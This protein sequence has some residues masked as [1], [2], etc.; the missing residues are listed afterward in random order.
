MSERYFTPAEVERL[1]P[2]LTRVME[3]VMGAHEEAASVRATLREE[4]GRITMSGGGVLD[5]AVWRERAGRL[6]RLTRTIEEGLGEITAMGGVT[7]DLRLGLVDFPHRRD[8]RVVNLCWK[9]G[10]KDIRYWHGLDEGYGGRKP[11]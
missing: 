1:I 10:E 2:D 9:H 4:Q 11:L 5:Q 3:R 8:G 7:K 6:T